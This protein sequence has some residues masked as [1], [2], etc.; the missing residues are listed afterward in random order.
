M[1]RYRNSFSISFMVKVKSLITLSV[2]GKLVDLPNG[3]F[4]NLQTSQ[5][6]NIVASYYMLFENN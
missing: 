4:V 3:G 2:T 5:F 1:V 6:T